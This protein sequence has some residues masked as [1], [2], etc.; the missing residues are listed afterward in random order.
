LA[1]PISKTICATYNRLRQRAHQLGLRLSSQN[2]KISLWVSVVENLT[3]AEAADFLKHA[4]REARVAAIEAAFEGG[5]DGTATP[6]PARPKMRKPLPREP[7]YAS[8]ELPP[9]IQFVPQP[10]FEM[11][12]ELPQKFRAEL[13]LPTD[14][15]RPT[16]LAGRV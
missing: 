13:L 3:F 8:V 16:H 6:I 5:M 4:N 15:A 12:V 11:H 9:R 1:L 7:M 2:G 14:T 10:K